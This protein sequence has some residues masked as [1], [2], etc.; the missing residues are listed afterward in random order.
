LVHLKG[1]EGPENG[2]VGDGKNKS[3]LE[4]F[5]GDTVGKRD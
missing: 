4:G 5:K 1:T 2:T 3:I